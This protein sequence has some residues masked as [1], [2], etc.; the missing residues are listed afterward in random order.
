MKYGAMRT[1]SS[2]LF[3]ETDDGVVLRLQVVDSRIV[4]VAVGDEPITSPETNSP[5]IVEQSSSD[6]EWSV[7]ENETMVT[8]ETATLRIELSKATCA[9]T[10]RDADG[11]L[12]VREPAEGGKERAPY[13][14]GE[15]AGENAASPRETL[16]REG[17][18]TKLTLEFDDDE[19]IYG[20]G[21]HDDGI[22]NYRGTD[23]YLY[24]HNTKVS[25]PVI[26]STRGYGILFDTYSLSTFHDDRHGSYFWSECVDEL[27]FY[28]VYG[29]ELDAVVS[30]F[31]QL[32][33]RA[34]MLPKW[35]YGYVQSKER[36]ETQ[37]ELLEIVDEYRDREIPLDCIVQDW[38]YWPDS[39]DD[40]P[41]FEAW[42]GPGGDWG[43]WGQKS[44]EPSRFPDPDALTERL[45]DRNVRLM[46]SIWPNMIVGEDFEEMADNG[47]LLDDHEL[48]A[49]DN[50]VNYY[51]A[52]STD[53]RERYWK[54]AESGLFSHGVDAWWAD[55]TE[56]YNPDWGLEH[57]LEPEQRLE[58]I[59]SDYKRVFD[60][61]YINAYSLYHARGI[62]E[63][64]RETTD[65]KRVLNLTRSGYPGQQRYGAVTWSG[66][67]EATWE[68]FRKQIADGLQFTATGNP[69]WTLDIGGFFVADNTAEEFYAN[70]DF[71]AGHEDCG[72]RELYTR[73]FQFGAF[74]PLFRSHGTDTPREVW[75]FGEPGDRIYDTLVRFDELRYR[76][77]PYIYSLAGWETHND[78]T[79]FR[80]L[81]FDFRGDDRVHDIADQFMFG[82]AL[83][84]CPVTEPMYYGPESTPLEGRAKARE[85]Y[86]P[87]GT[88]WYDFW[89]GERYDGGQTIL[90]DAPIEKLPLFVRAGSLL[91]MGPVVQHT[92]DRIDAPWE[93]RI[94]PGRDGS[95]ALYEDA[96]DGYEY[97]DG[98]YAI[99]PLRWDDTARELTIDD[100]AGTFAEL[101]ETRDIQPVVVSSGVGTGSDSDEIGS[102]V[103]YTGDRITVS[104]DQ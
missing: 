58:A 82:P 66:D 46:I 84:V 29:P 93:L 2:G 23:Q 47:H 31:R 53:A 87:A 17:Y 37:A 4:R 36:Y 3:V 42:G 100:R 76:L 104:T 10:W 63:G 45:H 13:D 18:S 9:L 54:Q 60:P 11:T 6:V 96:G 12:L 33:G 1:D 56:P 78:Y 55:S 74:L 25:M 65:E 30:G 77:L 68:R 75:R 67:V 99:T 51:D 92:A 71:D 70:G 73:W 8:L 80:H 83:L 102:A 16:E 86:L 59:T 94:Y 72:Y 22:A 98:E 69:K 38:Q 15:N 95:F 89:T 35:S 7:T 39:T 26:A 20:L 48:S 61:G 97:E 88:D 79:M 81:A 85:V 32:T 101:V 21:Q 49:P 50:E 24:Q 43:R 91:P 14:V 44:F 57:S 34:T 19:A 27:D 64:Q 41:D 28:F 5:M 62:Y 90:A 52:F 40:D 103:T